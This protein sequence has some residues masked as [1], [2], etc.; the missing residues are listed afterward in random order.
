MSASIVLEAARAVWLEDDQDV[1]DS[2]CGIGSSVRSAR[3]VRRTTSSTS[4]TSRK[5]VLDAMI[6][7][8]DFVERGLG[9]EA[10]SAAG[11]PLRPAAA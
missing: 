1:R 2:V 8:I 11:T 9:R 4:G 3:P 7:P 5:Q 6:Q 10:R